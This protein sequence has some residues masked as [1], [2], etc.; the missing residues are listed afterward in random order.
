[1]EKKVYVAPEAESV[2]VKMNQSIL[3]NSNVIK[4]G[5]PNQPPGSRSNR[6]DWSEE[7]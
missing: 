5:Q 7:D 1:M 2:I 4:P 6:N 3:E